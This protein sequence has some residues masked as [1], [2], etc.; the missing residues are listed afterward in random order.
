MTQTWLLTLDEIKL[1]DWALV[2][3]KA[4]NLAT[5]NRNNITTPTGLIVTTQFFEAQIRHFAYNPIWAGSPDVE[6]TEG[7]LKFLADFLKA[8]P[9]APH[10]D[11]AF[12]EHI[13]ANFS[14]DVESYAVRSSAVDEDL[15]DHSFAGCYLSELGV[16]RELL[17]VSLT[18]CWAAALTGQ[19]LEY[20]RKHGMSIQKIRIAILIQPMLKPQSGGVAFTLN[21]I[22][23]ARDEF[24]IEATNGLGTN[25]VAGTIKPYRYHVLRQ[26]PTYPLIEKKT[27][28]ARSHREPLTTRQLIAIAQMLEHVEAMMGTPQ[29]VEW[30]YQDDILYLLQARP[31][32]AMN[33]S[34]ET[35]FDTEWT[36]ANF[37]ETLPEIPSPLFVSVMERTQDR[38]LRFFSQIGLDVSGL[39]TYIKGIYGRPYLNLSMIKQILWQLGFSPIPILAMIGYLKEPTIMTNKARFVAPANPFHLDGSLVWEAR[40]SYLALLGETWKMGKTVTNY[41]KTIDNIISNLQVSANTPTKRLAQF[42]LREFVYGELIG[43]GLVLITTLTG[44]ISLIARII[45]PIAPSPTEIFKSLGGM[46][47]SPDAKRHNMT[48][49]HLGKHAFYDLQAR[50]YLTQENNDYS[51]YKTA[52]AGTQFLEMFEA[53]LKNQGYRA[54]YEAD[55]GQ[56]RYYEQTQTLLGTIAHYSKLMEM[57]QLDEQLQKQKQSPEQIWHELTINSGMISWRKMLAY[58]LLKLLQ[59]AF[60]LRNRMFTAES[61][62]MA[63][64]R[65][66]DLR[67]AEKWLHANLLNCKDD[68]FWLNMAEIEHTLIAEQDAGLHLKPTIATRKAAYQIYNDYDVPFV[69]KDSEV[70]LLFFGDDISYD[71]LPDTLMG[72]PVSPGQVHGKIKILDNLHDVDKV[73]EQTGGLFYG[74]EKHILVI[75]STDPIFLPILSSAAGLIIEMGG[76]LSHGSIIAREHG[77]PAVANISDARKRLKSGDNVLLDGTTGIIQILESAPIDVAKL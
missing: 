65:Q 41:E 1:N 27:G 62:G 6:V 48:M 35:T 63:T 32:T 59:K 75:P 12:K 10:L 43:T 24:I 70:P 38:G 40:S 66:W 68:Y 5:L 25:V 73:T 58:P 11:K 20:R 57:G 13:A 23:G 29:D 74:V 42:K 46:G 72:L 44:L 76:M 34:L 37:P 67:Q 39:G 15:H 18:R 33:S 77:I 9:L 26:S 47:K 30:A 31:I 71:N 28:E 51:D 55:M 49:M 56:T 22:T 7:A 3:G 52:L 64:V 53:Y 54:V 2:G 17:T 36:R 19:A 8:T 21:P 4:L 60:V 14:P 61:K 69:V 50:R 16:P 45:A